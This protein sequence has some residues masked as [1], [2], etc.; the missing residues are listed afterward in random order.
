MRM[1]TGEQ[2]TQFMVILRR[3]GYSKEEI[4]K[5]CHCVDIPE[6]MLRLLNVLMERD[7]EI[8]F[9]ELLPIAQKIE[10]EVIQEL[11]NEG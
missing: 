6:A 7:Y 1:I 8:P 9:K 11:P 4:F 2:R 5:V 10:E 3:M